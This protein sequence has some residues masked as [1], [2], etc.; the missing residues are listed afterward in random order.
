MDQKSLIISITI[1]LIFFALGLVCGF[2]YHRQ[3]T[4]MPFKAE[5]PIIKTLSSKVI[6]TVNAYGEVTSINEKNITLTSGGESLTIKIRD[7]AKVYSF[8]PSVDKKGNSTTP[9]QKI[10]KFEDIKN[11]NNVSVNLRILPDGN[12]EGYAVVI[13]SVLPK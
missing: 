2:F 6:P 13:V 5:N 8:E 7:D 1:G 11:G 10:I 9:V 12:I 3:I 4:F